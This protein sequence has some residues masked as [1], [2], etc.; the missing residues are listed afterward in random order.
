MPFI[1]FYGHVNAPYSESKWL[2]PSLAVSTPGE[3]RNWNS[4]YVPKSYLI[5][6]LTGTQLVTS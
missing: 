2:L 1:N 6:A 5:S 4:H 3:G